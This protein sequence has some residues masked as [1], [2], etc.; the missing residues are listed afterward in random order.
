VQEEQ[1]ESEIAH[2]VAKDE[3][4]QISTDT[5]LTFLSIVWAYRNIYK[6][7]EQSAMVC[8]ILWLTRVP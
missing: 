3:P 5:F 8:A 2:A 1:G 4:Q 7:R 6:V